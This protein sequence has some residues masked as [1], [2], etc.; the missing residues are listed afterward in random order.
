MHEPYDHLIQYI[1]HVSTV[2][3]I[4]FKTKKS[5]QIGQILFTLEEYFRH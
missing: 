4:F 2:K 3:T 5:I 1:I